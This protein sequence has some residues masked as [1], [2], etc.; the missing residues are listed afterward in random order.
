M[1]FVICGALA[2]LAI[3]GIIGTLAGIAAHKI[4]V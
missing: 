4:H 3:G 1:I 2:V